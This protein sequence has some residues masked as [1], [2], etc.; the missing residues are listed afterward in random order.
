MKNG[1]RV[2][3]IIILL[4]ISCGNII[5]GSNAF[6]ELSSLQIDKEK[7]NINI[8]D[9]KDNFRTD[10][11]KITFVKNNSKVVGK[12]SIDNVIYLE[13][14]K[15]IPENKFKHPTLFFMG[16]SLSPNGKIEYADKGKIIS[17]N[18]D[19]TL[20]A[21]WKNA[22][23][24]KWN[25]KKSTNSS[26]HVISQNKVK[27]PLVV[28]GKYDFTVS[29]GD[30][31][32]SHISSYNSL[33]VEHIY[34]TKN[35][36]HEIR[37][38]GVIIGWS[39]MDQYNYAVNDNLKIIEIY[40]WGDL[41][42]G[43]TKGQF[44]ECKNLNV[45]A[46]DAPDLSKTLSL[47]LAF[48]KCENLNNE[49]FSTWDT[50]NILNM[51]HMFLDCFRFSGYGLSN[52]STANVISMKGMFKN[53]SAFNEDIASWDTSRMANISEAF[54][55]AKKFNRDISRWEISNISYMYNLFYDS[56]LSGENFENILSGWNIY[57][58]KVLIGRDFKRNN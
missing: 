31:T 7:L 44:Y 1:I 16:W 55:S 45:L 28:N 30:G 10:K 25:T 29:W 20:Y 21:V 49:N 15:Y 8:N 27:L 58:N 42:L 2:S 4:L 18:K 57:S 41:A 12:M 47:N 17:K 36:I 39:F 35:T 26:L 14:G 48:A 22:F 40:N 32:I 19:I 34:K 38:S 46:S 3:L 9:L 33:D 54:Y 11:N 13:P 43:D 56:G 23:I 50:S 37:I 53:A 24:S 6:R 51:N 5:W 52:W